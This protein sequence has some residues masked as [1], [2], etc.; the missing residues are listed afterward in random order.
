M[1]HSA[2]LIAAAAFSSL[3]MGPAPA[4]VFSL[5]ATNIV[6]DN[7]FGPTFPPFVTNTISGTITLSNNIA[8]GGQFSST[9]VTA[10]SLDFFGLTGT[11]AD[12]QADIAPGPVQLFGT[13]SADGRS[14]SVF[15]FGFSFG[16]ATPV[17]GCEFDC[18]GNIFIN[19]P[20]NLDS[21]SDFIAVDQFGNIGVANFTPQ[22]TALASMVPEP[23]TWAMMILGFAGIV[24]I[25]YR[26]RKSAMLAA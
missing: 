14:F 5:S 17:A 2:L 12:V 18:V 11:L 24:A 6:F 13:V 3:A 20:P 25:R 15:D 21:D 9:D 7:N 19:S 26:C 23:S 16:F 1:R 10:L 22:F 4:T 8:P